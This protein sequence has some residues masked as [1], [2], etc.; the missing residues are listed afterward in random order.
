VKFN[1]YNNNYGWILTKID[2]HSPLVTDKFN[3]IG[4]ALNTGNS[5]TAM[6]LTNVQIDSGTV[7]AVKEPGNSLVP[8]QF[9]LSQNYPNP[10]NPT[11][12]IK[13]ALPKA[14]EV[15]LVVYDILGRIVT[16][17]V[18]GNLNAGYHTINFNASNF[19]SGVYF[20]SIKAGD[21]TSV[22]KL[23]LLK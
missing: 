14:S 1:L 16:T 9:E 13:F 4:F 22:K 11:T 10:F 19:A 18:N 21:F 15:H 6:N 5:V 3:S 8:T 7:T 12:T 23:M 17:L 2:N 20:Y